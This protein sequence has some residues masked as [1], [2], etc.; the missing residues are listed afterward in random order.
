MSFVSTLSKFHVALDGQGLILQ[1]SPAAPGYK[2]SNAPVYGQRFASGDRDYNDLSQWWYAIQTDWLG[3][4]KSDVSFKDDTK[5]YYS[6]NIDARTKPGTFRLEKQLTYVGTNVSRSESI[7]DYKVINIGNTSYPVY[8]DRTNILNTPG[9]TPL[10]SSGITS[11]LFIHSHKGYPWIFQTG[12][13][14]Y[15]STISVR[16]LAVGGGGGPGG[17]GSRYGGCGWQYFGGGGGGGGEVKDQTIQLN[18]GPNQ[19]IVGAN[20]G[21]PRSGQSSVGNLISLGGYSGAYADAG[22]SANG[23]AGGHGETLCV[24]DGTYGGAGG[25]GGGSG[26]VGSNGSGGV[27]GAG[28]AGTNSNITGSTVAYGAGGKGGDYDGFTGS[29]GT[30]ASQSIVII[31]Y[32]TGSITATGGTITTSGGNTIHTFTSSG[33]FNITSAP[34]STPIDLTPYINTKITASTTGVIKSAD[35]GISVSDILYILGVDTLNNA[36]IAKCSVANPSSS[37]DFTVLA[38]TLLSNGL[39]SRI[40][41]AKYLN[42]K[43]VFMV[44]G[45]PVWTLYEFDISTNI[46]SKIYDFENCVSAGIYDIG[47]RYVTD[48][49]PGKVIMTVLQNTINTGSIWEYDGSVLTKIYETDNIKDSFTTREATTILRG[50]CVVY[51]EYAYWGNLVYDGNNFFNFIKDYNNSSSKTALPI[52]KDGT[53]MY[54][55]DN[56]TTS[57]DEQVLVY[58]YNGYGTSYK[59]GSSRSAFLV[60]SQLD[61]VQSID[62]LLNTLVINFDKL[63]TGQEINVYYSLSP[64]PDPDPT[65]GGWSLLGSATYAS[66][67]GTITSKTLPFPVGTVAKKLW[68]RIELVSTSSGTPSMSDVTIEYLPMPDLKK[69]WDI[70]INCGDEVRRLDGRLVEDTGRELKSRLEKIWWTKSAI[71]FQDLDYASTVLSGAITDKTATTITVA[72]QGT[73]NFPEQGRIRI[74]DEEILYSG[75]TPNTFTGCVRGARGTRATTHSDLAVVHNAYKVLLM[76]IEEVAPIL[77]EDKNLE[78]VVSVNLREV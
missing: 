10:Y 26:G 18:F 60:M 61:K 49:T 28:G 20:T 58:T 50:G 39:S 16:V 33:T 71:D 37:S 64:S 66:D 51:G 53:Y 52:G 78:Y 17:G 22:S 25:G 67:G 2:M 65:I 56:V 15:S 24:A 63:T 1:G 13:L 11:P 12:G 9:G 14:S 72:A 43:I 74:D 32:P 38:N 54:I 23:N 35:I 5:F 7:F 8:T 31:S 68:T 73:A 59:N 40:I 46:I 55:V 76:R 69:E 70:R 30:A 42:G 41:G 36:F 3:G 4:F 21:Y 57:G 19:V 47:K 75:K 34:V 27:G 44:D 45:S 62:K 29:T 48:F 77:L 6:T